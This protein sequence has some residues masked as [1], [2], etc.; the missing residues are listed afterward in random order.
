MYRKYRT[1]KLRLMKLRAQKIILAQQYRRT[2][3][4]TA[5][6]QLLTRLK[7]KKTE[8][9]AIKKLLKL[10]RARLG[11]KHRRHR[12]FKFAHPRVRHLKLKRYNMKLRLKALR[13]QK[14]RLKKDIRGVKRRMSGIAR[15]RPQIRGVLRKQLRLKKKQL[16]ALKKLIAYLKQKMH[17]NHKS[18]RRLRKRIVRGMKRL[19]KRARRQRKVAMKTNTKPKIH[20]KA[21]VALKKKYKAARRY[22]RSKSKRRRNRS[23]KCGK[24]LKKKLRKLRKAFRKNV[25]R[26]L[27]RNV[28]LS[29]RSPRT[30]FRVNVRL[31]TA[32][33]RVQYLKIKT[34]FKAKKRQ[35]KLKLRVCRNKK[36]RVARKNRKHKRSRA[37]K[38]VRKLRRLRTRLSVFCKRHNTNPRVKAK[39]ARLRS[40]LR[41]TW[42]RL[43][44]RRAGMLAKVQ[45]RR[46]K[47]GTRAKKIA[48]R[49]RKLKLRLKMKHSRRRSNRARR[50]RRHRRRT[51]R[52]HRRRAIR[53]HSRRAIR[54]LRRG[55][56][57][58]KRGLRRRFRRSRSARLRSK[59]R[60]LNKKLNKAYRCVR[61]QTI[62]LKWLNNMNKR[63][64]K[65]FGKLNL[66][67]AHFRPYGKPYKTPGFRRHGQ[68][69]ALHG[70]VYIK[71]NAK[72]KRA[73][74]AKAAAKSKNNKST[75]RRPTAW[76]GI[77]ARLPKVCRPKK[78]H[79]LTV[80]TEGNKVAR[81]DISPNGVLEWVG[82]AR[83]MTYFSLDGVQF[84]VNKRSHNRRL[85]LGKSWRRPAGQFQ[86]PVFSQLGKWCA[87]SGVAVVRN[88]DLSQW[89]VPSIIAELPASCRPTDGQLTFYVGQQER[90]HRIDVNPS[91]QV[92]WVAGNRTLPWVS[93]DGI[94][95]I[96]SPNSATLA[97]STSF[98]T[99]SLPRVRRPAVVKHGNLCSL[100]GSVSRRIIFRA[101]GAK[102]EIA[103]LPHR[104]RPRTRLVFLAGKHTKTVASL[105]V[106]VLPTGK[107]LL[108]AGALNQAS[109]SLDGMAW[110]VNGREVPTRK[111][112]MRLPRGAMPLTR[113]KKSFRKLRIPKGFAPPHIVKAGGLCVASGILP[114]STSK[115]RFPSTCRPVGRLIFDTH[116]I[117]AGSATARV[118]VQANGQVVWVSG[119]PGTGGVSLDSIVFP[120]AARARVRR[121]KANAAKSAFSLLLARGW[122]NYGSSYAAPKVTIR[123]GLCSFSGLVRTNNWGTKAIN[124]HLATTPAECKPDKKLSF[125]VNHNDRSVPLTLLPSGRLMLS[126]KVNLTYPWVSLSGVVYAPKSGSFVRL[127]KRWSPAVGAVRAP[128]FKRAGS[129]CVLSGRV[130]AIARGRTIT[131][132]P[133]NCRPSARVSFFVSSSNR[134]VTRIDVLRNGRVQRQRV[135]R[136]GASNKPTTAAS[137]AV[138]R[139]KWV[140]LDGIHFSARKSS[141]RGGRK[142]LKNARTR[143]TRRRKLINRLQ[144]LQ[145]KLKNALKGKSKKPRSFVSSI[146]KRIARLQKKLRSRVKRFRNRGRRSLRR[147]HRHSVR[148]W[149]YRTSSIKLLSKYTVSNRGYVRPSY[150]RMGRVCLLAGSAD[151]LRATGRYA[152]LPRFCRPARPQSVN[153]VQTRNKIARADVNSRGVVAWAAGARQS[154]RIS[155]DGLT[156]ITKKPGRYLKRVPLSRYWKPVN[157]KVRPS[158]L[159]Q[160]G[161]CYLTGY[162]QPRS[163]QTTHVARLPKY[164][165]PKERLVFLGP[166]ENGETHIEIR[167]DGNVIFIRK[168]RTPN[169]RSS[170][171]PRLRFD[172]IAYSVHGGRSLVKALTPAVRSNTLGYRKPSFK[173]VRNVCFVSGVVQGNARVGSVLATL[174]KYCRPKGRSVFLTSG[175]I[176]SQT[177]EVNKAGR[178]VLRA[179]NPIGSNSFI[180]LDGIRFM[181]KVASKRALSRKFW[182]RRAPAPSFINKLKTLKLNRGVTSTANT[183]A[184]SINRF[185][186]LCM[187]EGRASTTGSNAL[188]TLPRQ[189]RPD[190]RKTFSALNGPANLANV[191]VKSVKGSVRLLRKANTPTSV[192]LGG[193]VFKVANAPGSRRIR[194]A[195]PWRTARKGFSRPSCFSQGGVIVLQGRMRTRAPRLSRMNRLVATLPRFCRPDR[196]VKLV[197]SS[198]GKQFLLKVTKYGQVYALAPSG[199]HAKSIDLDGIAFPA[200][201]G[202]RLALLHGHVALSRVSGIPSFRRSGNVCLLSGSVRP[203]KNSEVVT[204]LPKQCRPRGK[205]TFASSNGNTVATIDVFPDGRVCGEMDLGP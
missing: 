197:R 89:S 62:H 24:K 171:M 109:L 104:C 149:S 202:S 97:L 49:I 204:I 55:G 108:A 31:L 177:L 83:S 162:A 188:F 180:S 59:L 4:T 182:L 82:G 103:T 12:R 92:L 75:A 205:V 117:G 67:S 160:D 105:R 101:K 195:R 118:D 29:K 96:T 95:F 60:K 64:V 126:A 123:K 119:R 161:V 121:G 113:G 54:R 153:L 196:H 203:S 110:T 168:S 36:H 130:S 122:V 138:R 174:P 72:P 39:C 154:G 76:Q 21:I 98:R 19:Y 107:V 28:A 185:G 81:L 10:L 140:S 22:L 173:V 102:T 78:R 71:T 166:S 150:L 20:R 111:I 141:R 114:H 70:L 128:S 40:K 91:G 131:R 198:G 86:R 2:K 201:S 100:T 199:P 52:R 61:R 69:C 120:S 11:G 41:R 145:K 53:R 1:L 176:Y 99:S 137:L 116:T 94:S 136:F 45:K 135:R 66:V 87:L 124:R 44:A 184:P 193:A 56:R 7:L 18:I 43:V 192:H 144:R 170:R 50:F 79:V 151:G 148:G 183:Q 15:V 51:L 178:V 190:H 90:Q 26:L 8:I 132:L 142:A 125:T 84:A 179:V 30:P 147:R 191:R 38:A 33:Q 74:A 133:S 156:F 93:L 106:D 80:L 175:G 48:A 134:R 200:R 47:C 146:Q 37:K 115:I 85:K 32:K 57:K 164:C 14:R 63:G 163:I 181:V 23:K 88:Y 172:G 34:I 143:R 158:V 73:V 27:R 139:N 152:K 169:S 129:L 189:C 165:A 3:D 16:T 42:K 155:F 194:V 68:F 127:S 46:G 65:R 5:K 112:R 187:I 58:T 9:R 186:R 6:M 13:E 157:R 77:I 159:K 167:P 35:I 25:N 17:K